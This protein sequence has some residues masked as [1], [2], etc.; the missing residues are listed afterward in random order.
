[1]PTRPRPALEGALGC[2]AALTVVGIVAHLFT[3]GE[4][5]DARVLRGFTRLRFYDVERALEP[6]VHFGDPGP[7]L[8]ITLAIVGTAFARGRRRLALFAGVALVSAPITAEVLKVLTAQARDHSVRF[9]DHISNAS[10]PSGHTTGAMT[11]ALCALLVAPRA[12]RPLVAL[13]GGAYALAMG[14]TVIAL[15]WHFP[16]D[17]IGA[18]LLSAGFV[19]LAVAAARQ[20][21]DV[22]TEPD[23]APDWRSILTAAGTA[24]AILAVL[25]LTY[26][27]PA[28]LLEQA[29]RN[30]TLLA[31]GTV[32]AA[33]IAVLVTLV[34]RSAREL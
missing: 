23:A 34:A 11:A 7:Y 5:L 13:L 26:F 2:L 4:S 30:T 21:P 14:S 8:L 16:S 20:W 6:I 3:D 1:M 19:L 33:L 24:V 9:A 22:E 29:D 25:A 27:R 32:M 28:R 18:Y 12:A 17:V 15:V 10:W 31:A